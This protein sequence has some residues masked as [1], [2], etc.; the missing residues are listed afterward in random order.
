MKQK[1][2]KDIWTVEMPEVLTTQVQIVSAKLRSPIWAHFKKMSKCSVAVYNVADYA[3]CNVCYDE[4]EKSPDRRFL[5]KSQG[6][7]TK[8]T[9]HLSTNHPEILVAE[10]EEKAI[11]LLFDESSQK[12]MMSFLYDGTMSAN[13]YRYLKCVCLNSR[14]LS[15]SRLTA[16]RP[17]GRLFFCGVA[18]WIF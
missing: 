5:I 1:H 8:L 16:I 15:T 14:P 4:A 2:K 10:E 12:T 18:V 11:I 6:S 13:T 3:V 9:R 7:T 17:D